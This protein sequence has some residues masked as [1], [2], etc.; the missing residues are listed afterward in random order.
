MFPGQLPVQ[1]SLE[2]ASQAPP[3]SLGSLMTPLNKYAKSQISFFK[4]LILS[5]S[6]GKTYTILVE[7]ILILIYLSKFKTSTLTVPLCL[8]VGFVFLWTKSA[9]MFPE[10]RELELNL[11]QP[12]EADETRQ[13]GGPP[14]KNAC[15]R[16]RGGRRS[17]I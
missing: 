15:R 6:Y 11:V 5:S 4:I 16:P 9:L 8:N 2:C 14:S 3:S 1:V 7:C 10:C 12:L 13:T 17:Q